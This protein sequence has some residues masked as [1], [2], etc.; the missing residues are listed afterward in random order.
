[1]QSTGHILEI[2]FLLANLALIKESSPFLMLPLHLLRGVTDYFTHFGKLF[3]IP[4]WLIASLTTEGHF[5]CFVRYSWCI[6]Q[7]TF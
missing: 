1:M 2:P 4:K 7:A 3:S 6:I 5:L